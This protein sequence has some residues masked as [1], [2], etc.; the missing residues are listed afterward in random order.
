MHTAGGRVS[1][2]IKGLPYSARGEISIE[3]S[4]VEVNAEA[5]V[6]GS[7]FRTIK[8]KPIRAKITFDRFRTATG[9]YL[10]FD[11]NIMVENFAATFIEEDTDILHMLTGAGFT[12]SPDIN[13][14]NGEVSGLQ[15]EGSGYTR[16]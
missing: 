9:E 11:G 2:V 6:D 15:I 14:A 8:A 16:T 4:N 1:V 7:V 3:P 5:N 12:G 10:K 13:M